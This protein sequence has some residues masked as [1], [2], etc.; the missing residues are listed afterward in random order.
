M[1]QIT[2]TNMCLIKNPD[3]GEVLIQNRIKSWKGWAFPGGHVEDGESITDSVIREVREETGLTI[4]A[5]K[6][7][8]IKDWCETEGGKRCLVFLYKT[9]SYSGTLLTSSPEGE[10]FWCSPSAITEDLAA[11][12]FLQTLPVFFRKE[13]SE[14]FIKA[15]SSGIWVHEI[16]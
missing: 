7:C 16:K 8:G 11:E 4:H 3:T 14:D 1:E 6:L 9:N 2:L 13:L 15:T 5:P 10:H 12:G